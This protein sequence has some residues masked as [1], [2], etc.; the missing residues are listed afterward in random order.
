MTRNLR[1]FIDWLSR[2][3]RDCAPALTVALA[4]LVASP[5]LAQQRSRIVTLDRIVAVVNDDVITRLDLD[6][7]V[8]FA[9]LQL[10][11]QGT[12]PPPREALE[13]QILDRLVIDR[14][15]LQLAKETGLRVDDAELDKAVEVAVGNYMA[16]KKAAK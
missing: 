9:Y 12:P 3:I 1:P 16:R 14:A 5:V 6:E 11:Q 13:K 10:K 15:Q 2:A 4:L 7:R 8:R